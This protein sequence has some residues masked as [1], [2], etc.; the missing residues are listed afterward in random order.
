MSTPPPPPATPA[1]ADVAH[2]P[3]EDVQ[4]LVTGTLFMA[5]GLILMRDAHLLSGGVTGLAF[6]VHYASGWSLAGAIFVLNLPFYVLAWRTLGPAFT[7]KTF[8]AVAAL[9]GWTWVLPRWIALAQLEPVFAAVMGGLL[10]GVGI[11]MLIR[12]N[13]SLGGLTVLALFLQ[14]R[15][16]WRA[17]S[18]QLAC[19]VLILASALL[20]LPL[21][22]VALSVLAAVALNLV[23]A[24]N[25]RPDRYHGY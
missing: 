25:H 20:L 9:S 21:G 11:L 18:V 16:G 5:L 13:A 14:Q 19:D 22:G 23:I 3:L 15:R 8:A 10:G 17:G 7:F 1:T 6:L 12:H 24:I 2:S 4:G